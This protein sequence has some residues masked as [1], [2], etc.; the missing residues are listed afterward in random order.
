[1][2]DEVEVKRK[3]GRPRKTPF[4]SILSPE[5]IDGLQTPA[6]IA[7]RERKDKDAARKKFERQKAAA[8]KAVA[9]IETKEDLWQHNRKLLSESE[10]TALLEKQERV[11]DQVHWVNG[12]LDGTNLPPDDPDYVSVEEGAEDLLAFVKT[13][14]TVTMEV[15][16]IPEYWKTPLYRDKFQ[17]GT[18]PTSI[19]A[20]LGLVT[21]LPGHKVHQF[22]QFIAAQNVTSTA[23]VPSGSGFVTMMCGCNTL[24]GAEAV[25]TEIAEAYKAQ[26][27]TY[28]CRKCRSLEAQSRALSTLAQRGVLYG[29]STIFGA[30]G[31]Q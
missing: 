12:V 10:L 31:P 27:K 25:P 22:E 28:L 19:F 2:N 26:G 13:H 23:T 29:P 8:E 4:V 16:L 17:H 6:Q 1:M 11:F 14:G 7:D 9:D 20:R 15:A 18:D 5:V 21:A 3:P 30:G 24:T